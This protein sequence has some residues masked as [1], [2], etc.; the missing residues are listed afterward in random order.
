MRVSLF[1]RGWSAR[2]SACVFFF[3]FYEKVGDKLVEMCVEVVNKQQCACM[4]PGVCGAI[5]T[6]DLPQERRSSSIEGLSRAFSCCVV[7]TIPINVFMIFIYLNI[8]IRG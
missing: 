1:Y 8:F 2:L 6:R 3:F 5:C 7:R 4:P